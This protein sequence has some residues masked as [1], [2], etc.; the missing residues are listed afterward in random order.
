M[1]A[2]ARR[3]WYRYARAL[4]VSQSGVRRFSLTAS[5]RD[6]HEPHNNARKPNRKKFISVSIHHLPKLCLEC[7]FL[8]DGYSHSYRGASL[9]DGLVTDYSGSD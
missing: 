2:K 6:D 5:E 4:S 3:K 9:T 7:Q 1:A 8:A